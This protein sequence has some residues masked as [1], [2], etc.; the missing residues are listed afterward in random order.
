M[1]KI[2]FALVAAAA[3]LV[4]CQPKPVMVDKIALSSNTLSM[5][6]GDT[7]H[8]SAIV[9][10]KEATNPEVTWS[11]DN[12]SVATVTGSGDVTAVAP[13]EAKITVKAVDGSGV[14]A[15]CVVT[16]VKKVIPVTK[17]ELNEKTLSLKK[18]ETAQL[19]AVISPSDATYQNVTWASDNTDVATVDATGK[20]TAVA[21]GTANI[22]VG[23]AMTR[24]QAAR[25]VMVGVDLVGELRSQGYG[26]VATGEMGI[27]NTTTATAM[28][29][30]FLGLS[31]A[32][33]VG[34]GAGLSNEG[35]QRKR[36]VVE[37]ALAIHEPQAD[38][39]LDVLSKLGGFDI[40]GMCGLFLGGAV[41]RVPI[42]ADGLISLV[43][44]H[45]AWRMRPECLQAILA[46]H[47][48]AEPAAGLLLEGMGLSAPIHAGLRL[49]EGTG[50]VCLVPLLDMAL[51][52][53]D[54]GQSF[55]R[56]GIE[57]YQ[58]LT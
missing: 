1:K 36:A 4:G 14:S 5:V 20:V 9:S 18:D 25:A 30:A 38:D 13:G 29:C 55:A 21:A 15:T 16:V 49:G 43:A 31:P 44:A 53:Y 47:V 39:P 28:A 6:E 17:I 7:Q 27:G 33:L 48:S 42:V 58:A 51:A 45:C 52:V 41:H 40:A 24:E 22:A 3:L 11:S 26:L 57:A 8:L 2:L 56:L 10:P 50:A 35:L 34:R 32:Q 54:S 46:S 37:R 12:T 23:P 19:T